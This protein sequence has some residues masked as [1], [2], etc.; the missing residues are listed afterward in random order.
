MRNSPKGIL[1]AEIVAT[2]MR[3][4]LLG[5]VV[6]LVAAGVSHATVVAINDPV[7]GASSVIV[8]SATGLEWL[9]LTK[10]VGDSVSSVASQTG[11]TGT[12]AGWQIARD[13][14][15]VTL[16]NDAGPSTTL[17]LGGTVTSNVAAD[18]TQGVS[19]AQLLGLTST[20][21][22]FYDAAGLANGSGGPFASGIEAGTS[23]TYST[24]FVTAISDGISFAPSQTNPGVGVWLERAIPVPLPASVWLMLS[25]LG[26]LGF[27]ARA[28][29]RD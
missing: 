6:S 9:S 26:G 17:T 14:Q 29:P 16:L 1:A 2:F 27:A 13:S 4:I 20:A 15:V 3:T 23:P 22:N 28:R 8:D 19:T 7:W 21:A 5:G 18:V 10:T 25:A 12:Y 24:P 11:V